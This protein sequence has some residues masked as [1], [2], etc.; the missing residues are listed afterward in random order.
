M[1]CCCNTIGNVFRLVIVAGCAFAVSLAFLSTLSAGIHSHAANENSLKATE[2]TGEISY[3]MSLSLNALQY[4]CSLLYNFSTYT[5][6]ISSVR[7]TEQSIW[8]S[9]SR[10]RTTNVTLMRPTPTETDLWPV[11]G[12]L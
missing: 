6:V 5:P 2:L 11:P 8:V 10:A 7:L 3:L 9:G 12:L 4:K 1:V